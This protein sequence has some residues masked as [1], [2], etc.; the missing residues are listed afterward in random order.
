MITV[1]DRNLVPLTRGILSVATLEQI[2]RTLAETTDN[3]LVY[4]NR[5][6]AYKAYVCRDCSHTWRCP[7]C[8][9]AMT[10]HVSPK[11]ILLCHHCHTTLPVP[12]ACPTCHG[13]ELTGIG[14]AV[15]SVEAF[16]QREYPNV[17]IC[18]LDRDQKNVTK[19]ARIF[20]G[21]EYALRHHIGN[22]G[23]AIAL[24]PESELNIPE[25][26]IEERVYSNIRALQSVATECI[27][28][29]HAPKLPLIQDILNGNYKTFLTRTLAE[30]KRYHYPPYSGLAYIH[31]KNKSTSVLEDLCAKIDNKLKLGMEA[32]GP[33]AS[34]VLY[35]RSVRLKR[36]GEYIDTI[37]VRSDALAQ[38]LAPIQ[39]EMLR[40]RS[41][42]LVVR[43]E[44]IL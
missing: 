31:V 22:I 21:T 40:N 42:E 12:D 43:G 44:K 15:Q 11:Q 3:I 39:A 30:R 25:F 35:D 20:L 26:D 24:L 37:M 7:H 14:I 34:Q 17:E 16:L 28:E 38:V 8:D 23:M 18:R 2:S 10:L 33:N 36:A 27:V 9:V 32:T 5:R 4:L 13:H 19:T 29:T 1:I 6:G 41:I